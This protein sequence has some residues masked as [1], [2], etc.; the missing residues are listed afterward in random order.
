MDKAQ[1]TE[2]IDE[3]ESLSNKF[4]DV[5][6]LSEEILVY[7][8]FIDAWTIKENI[9]HC[10]DFDIANFHRYRW[11]I[12]SPG[13]QVLSFDQT[14]TEKLEYNKTDIKQSLS[15]IAM[16]RTLMANHLRI[17]I[18][19]DWLKYSYLFADGKTF[20]LEEAIQH[21]INHVFF[22]RKL[23]DRNIETY[24]CNVRKE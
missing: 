12:T 21:C 6:S 4:D 22:H 23:I 15:V 16:I 2:L 11:A 7:R 20:H 8:P 24:N 1:K 10:L 19:D 13:T 18:N 17:I 5:L 14:W 9:V 3:F